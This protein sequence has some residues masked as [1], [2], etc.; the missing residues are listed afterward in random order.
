MRGVKVASR[1]LLAT[2]VLTLA[3]GGVAAALA[4]H[5]GYRAYAVR[6]ASMAPGPPA[7]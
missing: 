3:G 7:R 6:T 1:V 5:Q 2:V 4:H